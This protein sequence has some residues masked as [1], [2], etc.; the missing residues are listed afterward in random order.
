V[1]SFEVSA[2]F[3]IPASAK[4]TGEPSGEVAPSASPDASRARP[5]LDEAGGPGVQLASTDARAR[6]ATPK[7]LA[8]IRTAYCTKAHNAGAETGSQPACDACA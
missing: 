8:M 6:A 2:S 4:G 5:L 3:E 7:G 1:A